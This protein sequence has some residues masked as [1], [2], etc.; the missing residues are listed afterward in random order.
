MIGVMLLASHLSVGAVCKF[1]CRQTSRRNHRPHQLLQK[2]LPRG[3]SVARPV[4]PSARPSAR[5]LARNQGSHLLDTNTQQQRSL[6]CTDSQSCKS[7]LILTND[8]ASSPPTCSQRLSRVLFPLKGGAHSNSG[9]PVGRRA[10]L[11]LV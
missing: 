3:H 11:P 9:A 8:F 7:L 4:T 6:P 5:R 2:L 10:Y 1:D